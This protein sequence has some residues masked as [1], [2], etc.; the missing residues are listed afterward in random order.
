MQVLVEDYIN[1][2]GFD[3]EKDDLVSLSS[4]TPL[5][6]DATDFLLSVRDVDKEKHQIFVDSRL[7]RKDVAFHDP[8]KRV[9]VSNF[10]SAVKKT[11][12]KNK[13][14]VD[15]NRDILGK[16][17]ST[18]VKLGKTV[19]FEK[20]LKCPLG[21]VLLSLCNTDGSMRKTNK[22]NLLKHI[23]SRVNVDDAREFPKEKTALIVDLMAL[24]RTMSNIPSTF[25]GLA[26]KM[27]SLIPKGY[28]RVDL[29]AECYFETSIKDAERAKR[30]MSK[31]IFIKSSQ[32]KIPN[33][34]S[35]FLACCENKT[36]LVQLVFETLTNKK[37]DVLETLRSD[38]LVLSSKENCKMIT[39]SS[40]T[41]FKRLVSTEEEADTKV[42][43]H[44]VEYLAQ[45][46]NHRLEKLIS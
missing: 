20:A 39:R 30:G 21:E 38:T 42:I 41:S 15:V 33:E 4:G 19:D 45:K 14:S 6:L 37:E 12:M 24:L 36:R 10:S 25:D 5:N 46:E 9:K 28:C 31:K 34:F 2:F 32:S 1:P 44:A 26:W 43:A 17:L 11:T 18:S 27:I 16:L 23:V 22:I 8:I 13:K 35:K 40:V 3:V 29:V 7:R